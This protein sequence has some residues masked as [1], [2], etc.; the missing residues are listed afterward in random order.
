MAAAVD[1]ITR[2]FPGT[3]TSTWRSWVEQRALRV[4]FERG[5][6]RFPAERPGQST[7]HT[8]LAFDYVVREGSSSPAQLE[9]GAAWVAA[10][11]RWNRNDV[12][13]FEHPAAR[14]VLLEYEGNPPPRWWS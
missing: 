3:L 11:G 9:L 12:I 4:A 6:S 8:G 1:D 10:G 2:V 5:R 13:H 14:S 7:H